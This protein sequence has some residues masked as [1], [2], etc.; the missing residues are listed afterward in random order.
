MRILV[1]V[2]QHPY[3][4][5]VVKD[6][7]KLAGNTWADVTFLG[8]GPKVANISRTSNKAGI[9]QHLTEALRNYRCNFLDHFD[10]EESPYE[11]RSYN[12]EFVEV[13]R[14]VWEELC[15]CRGARKELKIVLRAGNPVKEILAQSQEDD[16]DLI[17]MGCYKKGDCLWKGT[18]NLPQK[19]AN[20]ASCSVLVIKKEEKKIRK[21]ACCLDQ[22]NI[23]QKSIEM[24]NQMVTLYQTE[25]EIVGLTDGTVLKP[26]VEKN[27]DAILKYYNAR[28]IKAWIKLVDAVSMAS[29]ISQ[30]A[31]RSM[32]ALWMGEHSFLSKMF[33]RGKVDKLI[34]GSESSVLLLR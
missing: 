2:D 17:A 20:N 27:L 8:V 26:M 29:F 4:A 25:L 12:Y 1:A 34:Q 13:K 24:I 18:I 30:E 10:K 23:S 5:H 19:V 28:Q 21:I 33:P 7:A 6:V 22:E 31:R 14:G 9:K 15:V 32:M 16:C 11:K 3:S